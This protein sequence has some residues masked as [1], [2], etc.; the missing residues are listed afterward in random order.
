MR[1]CYLNRFILALVAAGLAAC[2][3]S[4]TQPNPSQATQAKTPA[5]D[6]LAAEAL[7]VYELQRDG[8]RALSLISAAVERAP[9]RADLAHLQASLCRLIEG[10]RPED[11]E[12]RVRKLDEGNAVVW[13]RA[14]AEAQRRNER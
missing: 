10:C 1:S 4:P 2:G 11:Y 5:V 6:A 3:G 14:L 13:A 8:A 9:Q 12:L 7:A